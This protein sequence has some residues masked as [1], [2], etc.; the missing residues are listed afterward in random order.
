VDVVEQSSIRNELMASLP[1]DILNSL[2]PYFRRI[3]L[4]FR[5]TLHTPNEPITAVL[6][7]EFGY[8]SM[9]ATLEDGDVAEVGMIGRE[10]MVGVSVVLEA[11]SSPLEAVVQ[12]EGIALRLDADVF[13]QAL[14]EKPPLRKLMLR[15]AMAFH[16][17]VTMTAACNGRHLLEQ[18]LAR[19][20]L[21][22]H[23]RIDGDELPMTHEF[24]ATMLG[25]RRAGITVAAGA[26]Q[27]AGFIRYEQGK[28][29]I[30]DRPGLEAAACECRTVVKR[31]FARLLGPIAS[32]V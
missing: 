9:L 24:L 28:I 15:Y 26:L 10:G 5:A 18:R 4:P 22:A 23:D 27:K 3:E 8:A 19:W 21:E 2:L 16:M 1:P 32:G 29:R 7:P 17:Q 25:V 31:E 30:I 6:F 14:T 12:A 11:D 13:Q 20:L